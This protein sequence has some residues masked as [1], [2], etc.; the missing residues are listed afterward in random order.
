MRAM[1]ICGWQHGL[2]EVEAMSALRRCCSPALWHACSVR[3]VSFLTVAVCRAAD[4]DA[5][6][7]MQQ[8]RAND[9][10]L[11]LSSCVLLIAIYNTDPFH[12]D[13]CGAGNIMMRTVTLLRTVMQDLHNESKVAAGLGSTSELV[14]AI[15]RTAI[16]NVKKKEN[17]MRSP[18]STTTAASAAS[19]VLSR[20]KTTTASAPCAAPQGSS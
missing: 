14:R 5:V 3:C 2:W 6:L 9:S 11:S 8:K 1:W 20:H 16:G 12:R 17:N 19:G 13:H 4:S 18:F 7:L 10:H 15:F